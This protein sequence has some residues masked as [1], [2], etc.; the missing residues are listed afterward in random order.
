MENAMS[1]SEVA[2]IG[3]DSGTE[4]TP[5]GGEAGDNE[6]LGNAIS[7]NHLGIGITGDDEW[8]TE[9]PMKT[10][11]SMIRGNG[12]IVHCVYADNE[13]CCIHCRETPERCTTIKQAVFLVE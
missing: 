1:Y 4:N 11:G 2:D 3:T 6:T 8:C 7:L 12:P 5:T 10:L 13:N 9:C